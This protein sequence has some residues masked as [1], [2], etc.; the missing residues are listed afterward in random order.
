MPI[1]WYSSLETGNIEIDQQHKFFVNLI[2]RIENNISDSQDACRSS[3][4]LIELKKYMDFHFC[5]EENIAKH[6]NLTGLSEHHDKHVE[7]LKKFIQFEEQISSGEKTL[8]EFLKF[9][10]NWF[11]SH[12][13]YEDQILFNTQKSEE[14]DL[15]K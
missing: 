11:I 10:N 4:L 6:L 1:E 5:S 14:Q 13:F 9:L 3:D 15:K 8:P 7:I 2:N 12:T